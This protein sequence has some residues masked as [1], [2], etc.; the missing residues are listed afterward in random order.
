VRSIII[1]T[2]CL[3]GFR[4]NESVK[5]NEIGFFIN[6]KEYSGKYAHPGSMDFDKS[7]LTLQSVRS[8]TREWAI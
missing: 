2:S 4:V 7:Q 5:T 1:M 3:I 8:K 6:G